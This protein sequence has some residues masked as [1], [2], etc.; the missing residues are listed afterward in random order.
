MA[1]LKQILAKKTDNELLF[2]IENVDKHTEEAVKLALNEL[3]ERKVQLPE[4]ITEHIEAQLNAKTLLRDQKRENPWKQNI[5]DDL[6]AP[7]FYSQTAIYIFSILFSVFFGA[8]ML[9]SNCK[10]VGKPRWPVILSG[11][12]YSLLTIVILEYYDLS[13]PYTYIANTIGI[14]FMYHL[15]WTRYIDAQTKYRA[16]PI[17]KPLV[18]AAVIFIPFIAMIIYNTPK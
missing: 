3:Q 10:D 13:T 8:F 7:L 17:W 2:Y 9:A 12:S 11:F 4:G 16:K 14:T 6:D 5:V 1:A 18:I 15:F